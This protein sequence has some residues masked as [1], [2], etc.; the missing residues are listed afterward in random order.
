MM[1]RIRYGYFEEKPP[2]HEDDYIAIRFLINGRMPS[3][4]FFCP[5]T[6][7]QIKPI[8]NSKQEIVIF[9]LKLISHQPTVTPI[10]LTKAYTHG[11]AIF[12]PCESDRLR[13][14]RRR[15]N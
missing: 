3:I 8:L 10:E 5:P 13:R 4:Y 1:R 12:L 14:F 9:S 11:G 15:K 6:R 2:T 7:L